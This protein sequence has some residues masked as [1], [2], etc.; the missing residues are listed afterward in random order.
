M[1][2]PDIDAEQIL[3]VARLWQELGLQDAIRLELNSLGTLEDRVRYREALVAYLEQHF[4]ALDED[5]QRRLHKNPL[6]ILDSKNPMMQELIQQA[7]Q[8]TDFLGEEARNHFTGLCDLLDAAGVSYRVN[9]RIVRG[10]DYYCL[11]VYEWITDQLGA[12][13]TVCAGGR[14]DRLVSDLGGKATPAVGYAIGLERMIELL[15]GK[16]KLDVSSDVYLVMMGAEAERQGIV[17]A[18]RLRTE[19][20][21]LRLIV[22]VGG[23]GFK[24]QFKRADKSGARF[25]LILGEE[26]LK[27]GRI[28][29]KDLRHP[30]AVQQLYRMDEIIEKFKSLFKILLCWP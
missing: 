7:P 17:L 13:G 27:A 12:Q 2:G 4:E 22:N 8:L 3:M 5:S 28:A 29:L 30:E 19:L 10:L 20:P 23:G 6:R 11:T 21:Q 1:P 25:A 26:E 15:A 9:P 14:Y 24:A 18:E 16:I